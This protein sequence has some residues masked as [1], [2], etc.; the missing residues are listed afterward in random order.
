M[1]LVDARLPVVP[2]NLWNNCKT[3]HRLIFLYS[4][5]GGSIT[6]SHLLGFLATMINL[7]L[8]VL[9]GDLW[10]MWFM[11]MWIP[12]LK[13]DQCYCIFARHWIA[14]YCWY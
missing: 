10:P 11:H 6:L 5:F 7:L 3:Y 9:Q 13:H 4:Q 14:Y 12:I 8:H 1:N 2:I